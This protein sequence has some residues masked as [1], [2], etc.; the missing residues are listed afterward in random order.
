MGKIIPGIFF[1]LTIS[2]IITDLIIID[3]SSIIFIKENLVKFSL[4]YW[5]VVFGIA[6]ITGIS[7]QGIAEKL[8]LIRYY[9]KYFNKEKKLALTQNQWH[10]MYIHFKNNASDDEKKDFERM[11]VIKEACGN[12][13]V[14]LL[15]SLF[16]ISLYYYPTFLKDLIIYLPLIVIAIIIILSL[17]IFHFTHVERQYSIMKQCDCMKKYFK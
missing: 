14:S 3:S 8:K 5:I 1:I 9:P 17:C 12:S 11:V 2:V 15:I 6:W 13:Y 4:W 10:E 16:I 7:I